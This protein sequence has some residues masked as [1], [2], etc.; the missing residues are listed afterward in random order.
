MQLNDP[1]VCE[2]CDGETAYEKREGPR[3]LY[4][5]TGCGQ[6]TIQVYRVYDQDLVNSDGLDSSQPFAN[7]GIKQ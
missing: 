7:N 2:H 3:L 6:V 4:R 5:C 1:F